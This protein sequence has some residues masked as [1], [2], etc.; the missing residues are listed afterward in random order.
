MKRC[1]RIVKYLF[2]RNQNTGFFL[3]IDF[4]KDVEP[5]VKVSGLICEND[6]S[7]NSLG[8]GLD[9]KLNFEKFDQSFLELNGTQDLSIER[10]SV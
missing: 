5:F 1:R 7:Q 4:R 10:R 2:F 3:G 8:Y 6:R 9:P